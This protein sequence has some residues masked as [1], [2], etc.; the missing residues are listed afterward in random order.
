MRSITHHALLAILFLSSC[1]PATPSPSQTVTVY[2]TSSAQF[3]LMDVYACAADSSVTLKVDANEPDIYLRLGEPEIFVSPAYQIG[4]EEILIVTHPDSPLQNLSLL[5]AQ[6]IFAQPNPAVQ[7]WIFSA[8]EDIQR[9]FD[10]LVMQGRGVTS[11]ARMAGS[12]GQMS[13]ALSSESGAVGILPKRALTGNLRAVFSAGSVP[14][15]A[16]TQQNP[17]GAVSSLIACLQK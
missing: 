7:V 17:Q 11:S 10:S 16:L 6:K 9:A 8:G 14:V 5:E 12:V 15:L 1:V 2:A 3:W 4:E 13:S